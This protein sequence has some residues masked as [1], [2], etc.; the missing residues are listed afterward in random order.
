MSK[1]ATLRPQMSGH[2][3]MLKHDY[4]AL[5]MVRKGFCKAVCCPSFLKWH[6]YVTLQIRYG[7]E[8][9]FILR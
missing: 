4:K 9:A 2:A 5:G 8:A 1:R 7:L 3:E 6:M